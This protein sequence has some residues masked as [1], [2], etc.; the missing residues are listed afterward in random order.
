MAFKKTVF[1]C[2]SLLFYADRVLAQDDFKIFLEFLPDSVTQNEAFTV[3]LVVSHPNPEEVYVRAPDFNGAFRMERMH[4]GVRLVR[5]IT[6]SNEKYTVFEFLLIPDKA[7]LQEIGAFEVGVF[8]KTRMSSPM[9]VHVLPEEEGFDARL[10]WL[11]RDGRGSD[12]ASVRIGEVYET[13]L[14]IVSWGKGRPYPETFAP[15]IEAP[16]NA[17]VEKIPLSKND[18]GTGIVLRLR[19]VPLDGKTVSINAQG[20]EYEKSR[21]GIPELT[22]KVLPAAA[23]FTVTESPETLTA[24]KED[25]DISRRVGPVSFSGMTGD[26]KKTIAVFRRG[27]D[28][29][30]AEAERFWGEGE[31]AAALAVLRS[32][33]MRLTAA[34]AVRRVRIACENALRLPSGANEPRLPRGTVLFVLALSAAA[35]AV[36]FSVRKRIFIPAFLLS[37]II[38]VFLFD[39]AALFFSYSYEKNRAVLKYCAAYPIPEEDAGAAFFFME[40]EAVNIRSKSGSWFF[41]VRAESGGPEKSGWI[42]KE[43]AVILTCLRLK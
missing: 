10:V 27:P 23:E 43:D 32:G 17:I 6:Q 36:L 35:F 11:G 2:A 42:K 12:G 37:A 1:F 18:S 39:L 25:T 13:A 3:N 15:P 8:G 20:L 34:S 5:D 9:R 19:I 24:K 21:I 41:V 16:E 28:G 14:R 38:F 40:G 33:E 31:Y 4:T 29:C 22:I 7:G 26:D 30:I